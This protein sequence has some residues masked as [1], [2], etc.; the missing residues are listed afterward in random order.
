MAGSDRALVSGVP[1]LLML[2]LLAR[3]SMYGYELAQQV[4]AVLQLGVEPF[5]EER[6]A[7]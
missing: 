6:G 4:D 1:E 5:G 2:Q 3:R 7:Q